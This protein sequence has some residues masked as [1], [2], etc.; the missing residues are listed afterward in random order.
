MDFLLIAEFIAVF[1]F[2]LS[3]AMVASR[4]QLDI[5][6]FVFLA[7][8]TGVGGGTIRDIILGNTPVFW[9]NSPIYLFVASSSA[10]A[11]FILAP[12][13]ESRILWLNWFDAAAL[14]LTVPLAITITLAITDS[15]PIV[16]LMA[17]MTGT[18]GGMMRDVI[19]NEV[20]LVL[21][22]G[23]MY[24]SAALGG[25]CLY[26]A[27]IFLTGSE[28]VAFVVSGVGTAVLRGGSMIFG[29]RLPSYHTQPP[30]RQ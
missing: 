28:T 22:K 9:V 12:K 16:L 23:E 1:V 2:G 17:V 20:P 21:S 26:P 8:I 30:K 19:A 13:L 6:G 25:A 7:C 18:F 15:W 5:V 11:G 3:G 27:M 14:A 4:A 24:V 10:I 29:W